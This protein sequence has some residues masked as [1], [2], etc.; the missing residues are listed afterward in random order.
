MNEDESTDEVELIRETERG[1]DIIRRNGVI[2]RGSSNGLVTSFAGPV[3]LDEAEEVSIR[4]S[5]EDVR[6]EQ[7][8]ENE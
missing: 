1:P 5:V 7:E 8:T 2:C 3:P 6:L 4:Q